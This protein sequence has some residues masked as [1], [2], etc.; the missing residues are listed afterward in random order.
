MLIITVFVDFKHE[1]K[2]FKCIY[3]NYSYTLKAASDI[4]H[5]CVMV[6]G[7]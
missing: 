6:V 3:E 1:M 4:S 5:R 2:D 7:S